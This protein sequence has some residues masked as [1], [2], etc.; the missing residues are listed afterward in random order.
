MINREIKFRAWIPKYKKMETGLFGLRS[1][2]L[3]SFNSIAILMQYTG[4]KDKN[5]VEIYEGDI[6]QC[7]YSNDIAKFFKIK[8]FTSVVLFAGGSFRVTEVG[9][10][11]MNYIFDFPMT[12]EECYNDNDIVIG[13]MYETPELHNIDL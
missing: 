6:L 8:T 4:Y 13:N 5:G 1:D 7:T 9:Y 11:D 10:N 2:G 12:L 3:T